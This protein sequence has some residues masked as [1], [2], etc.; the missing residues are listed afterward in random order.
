M[1]VFA[2]LAV[3]F[4]VIF[5][6]A[7]VSRAQGIVPGGWDPVIGYQSV[8]VTGNNP[9]QGQ[10]GPGFAYSPYGVYSP[11]MPNTSFGPGYALP[12]R[13]VNGLGPLGSV[14]RRTTRTRRVR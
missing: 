3:A 8:G 14:V 1:R 7:S 5:G 13:T 4:A 11:S 12:A 10:G 6:T 2:S 9:W